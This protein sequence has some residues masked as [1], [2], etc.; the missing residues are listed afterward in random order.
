MEP[1]VKLCMG[2]M[3]ELGPDGQ[4]HYCSYSDD[5]PHLQSYLAPKTVL[6]NRY[7][8]GKMLSYNGEGA[9]YICYDMVGKCKCVCREYM[10]DT[11][12]ER[13]PDGL[14]IKVNKDCLAKYKTF[15]SEFA[16]MN[17]V[18]SRMRNLTHIVTAKDMFAENN[19]TYVILEYVEGVSLK[20][21][22]QSNTGFLTWEQVKKLFVPLFTTL[23]IIHNSGII[24]RGIS[25]ENIIVTTDGELKLT[26]FCI[27][28]IRT[29]NTG[30][31]PEF[32]SG[33][34][35][36]EQYSSLQWQGTWTDVYAVAAVIYRIL[37]GCMPL[38][39][40]TRIHNDTLVEANRINPRIPRH[41][42]DALAQAMAVRGEERIQTVT[43]LVSS[44]FEQPSRMEH[45]K[46]STQ[47][48]PI[49]H[50]PREERQRRSEEEYHVSQGK[51][52]KKK[53]SS[54]ATIVGFCVLA[55]LLGIGIY[56]MTQLFAPPEEGDK[57][58]S[59]KP[60]QEITY[61]DE[62]EEE[63]DYEYATTT[64]VITAEIDDTEYGR[65]SI[66]PNIVG[67]IYSEVEKKMGGEFTLKPK[68]YYSD[69]DE[70]GL[71]KSQSI[72]EGSDYDPSRKNELVMDVCAGP[73][74]IPV[75]DSSG[76]T[77]RD[78]LDLLDSLNIKYSVTEERSSLAQGYVTRTSIT[79]GNYINVEKGETLTVYVSNGKPVATTT[80]ASTAA[81]TDT[82]SETQQWTDTEP[83]T[84][85]QAW[86]D[87]EA[88]A[89]DYGGEEQPQ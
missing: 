66:M 80:A 71:V 41:I 9:S 79:A 35:A 89:V 17:K 32:Y 33:Y 61:D 82:A 6:D 21:F 37:T 8:I 85:T 1:S 3:N 39:A 24:H 26:G 70:R 51:P 83:W 11:L 48:I 22:L 43:E 72:P 86:T 36:P 60:V 84:D 77:K 31:M 44:L 68:Y 73:S 27:S 29:S 76:Y 54:L 75:P 7:V 58:S 69:T 5:I 64:T 59:S 18:L 45:P 74:S 23:N 20:K 65:G 63:D 13:E 19:T 56:L 78:Y 52:R 40:N 16:D 42:S 57:S 67:L 28:S 38:D 55:V 49:Q 53:G 10:P 88:P 4:C 25:P 47:T 34:T 2:C 62:S 50:V 14:N 30:M 15:M 12:C 87:T 81:Q 46:G